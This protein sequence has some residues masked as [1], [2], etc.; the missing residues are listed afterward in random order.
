VVG[1]LRLDLISRLEKEGIVTEIL[2]LIEKEFY[3][4][5]GV[6]AMITKAIP[7]AKQ[8]I[9]ALLNSGYSKIEGNAL[10][11]FD[12]YYMISRVSS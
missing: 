4:C 2:S 5:F 7:S 6:D 10:V 11:S 3:D 1:V 8:R 12:D 9:N